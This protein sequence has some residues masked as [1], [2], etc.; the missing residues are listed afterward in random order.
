MII[1]IIYTVSS[2]ENRSSKLYCCCTDANTNQG[3]KDDASNNSNDVRTF[4]THLFG[5]I[6]G[7]LQLPATEVAAADVA[8]LATDFD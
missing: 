8:D 4:K 1:A 5:Q 2:S 7:L 6:N 3:V